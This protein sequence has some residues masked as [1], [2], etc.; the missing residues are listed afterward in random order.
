[1]EKTKIKLQDIRVER[2]VTSTTNTQGKNKSE[3]NNG[4]YTWVG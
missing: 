1:M 3:D 4:G 2:F